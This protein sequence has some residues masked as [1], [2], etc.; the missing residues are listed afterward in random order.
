MTIKFYDTS[1]LLLK[2]KFNP[3]EEYVVISIITLQELEN[4]KTSSTTEEPMRFRVR[5]LLRYI[6]EHP[7]EIAV[8]CAYDEKAKTNDEKIISSAWNYSKDLNASLNNIRIVT[9]KNI[10]EMSRFAD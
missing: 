6:D 5:K 3:K 8:H 9:G 2:E 4:L 7:N 1:A 10:D